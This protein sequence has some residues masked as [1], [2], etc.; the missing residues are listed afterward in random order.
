MWC[1]AW[2]TAVAASTG[3]TSASLEADGRLRD[4]RTL[5]VLSGICGVLILA[6]LALA[7]GGG[8]LSVGPL[9]LG[10]VSNASIVELRDHRGITVVAGE[11]RSRVDPLGDTE[12]DAAL[13][14]RGGRTIVGEVEL[15]IPAPGREGRRPEIEVDVIGLAP[16]AK[17]T[18]VIDDRTVA[19]FVTDDRGSID[20]EVQEGEV[21][22]ATPD[23]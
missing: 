23:I 22:A 21:P 4:R 13:M 17:F 14:D 8:G 19:E 6:G 12:K 16:R 2:G 9:T 18:V 10:D 11:F 3:V 1:V 7:I 20:R 5:L 15:E